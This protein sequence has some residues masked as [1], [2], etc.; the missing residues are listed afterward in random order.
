MSEPRFEMLDDYVRELDREADLIV[1][2]TSPVEVRRAGTGRRRRQLVAIVVVLVVVGLAVAGLVIANLTSRSA[3]PNW[4]TTPSSPVSQTPS[5]A[6]PATTRPS[7]TAVI[8]GPDASA[9]SVAPSWA[10]C[11][12]GVRP[13]WALRGTT[14]RPVVDP[15]T[16]VMCNDEV[17]IS[18]PGSEPSTYYVTASTLF[19]VAA[20]LDTLTVTVVDV[21][22]DQAVTIRD[23]STVFAAATI[24]DRWADSAITG[25]GTVQPVVAPGDVIT[26]L[27]IGELTIGTPRSVL[28]NRSVLAPVGGCTVDNSMP[29]LTSEGIAISSQSETVDFIS[30]YSSL[31][32]TQSGVALGMTMGKVKQVYGDKVAVKTV[33][34][35]IGD[36]QGN[37]RQA[38]VISSGNNLVFMSDSR[39]AIQASDVVT[40]IYLLKGDSLSVPVEIC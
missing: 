30:V 22:T 27:G 39:G 33:T 14:G 37:T 17:L 10:V 19:G 24:T 3:A 6:D 23:G 13:S 7:A 16:I 5:L 29:T 31:H 2:P 36:P 8:P 15:L 25:S 28:V 34:L 32:S 4:A 18:T 35:E 21:R 9:T 1:P 38:Y 40:Q 12:P 26:M 11:G 20:V